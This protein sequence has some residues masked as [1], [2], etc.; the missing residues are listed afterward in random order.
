MIL[1]RGEDMSTNFGF[2]VSKESD[3]Y[4]ISY[5][6]EDSKHVGEICRLL[7]KQGLP[8]WYD[9]G[10]KH[11]KYWDAIIAERVDNCR[12]A[13]FFITEG[14]FRKAAE[15]GL[16]RTNV[17]VYYEYEMTRN[18]NKRALIVMLEEVDSRIVPYELQRWWTEIRPSSRQGVLAY[19]MSPEQVAQRILAEIK[20]TDIAEGVA[21]VAT[22]DESENGTN[23]K[24][25]RPSRVLPLAVSAL[26]I[27]IVALL[28]V[29]VP[30]LRKGGGLP[31]VSEASDAL[32]PAGLLNA[33][34]SVSGYELSRGPIYSIPYG[35][36]VEIRTGNTSEVRSV[37]YQVVGSEP[38]WQKNTDHCIVRFPEEAGRFI[39]LRVGGLTA[40]GRKTEWQEYS[41][42]LCDQKKTEDALILCAGGSILE[43]GEHKICLGGQVLCLIDNGDREITQVRYRIDNGTVT[44]VTRDFSGFLDIETQNVSRFS[45]QACGITAGGEETPWQ[46]YSFVKHDLLPFSVSNGESKL[47]IGWTYWIDIDLPV[48]LSAPDGVNVGEFYYKIGTRPME[49]VVGKGRDAIE[50]SIPKAYAGTGPFSFQV[51]YVTP[52]GRQSAW[53]KYFLVAE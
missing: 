15:Y 35:M 14:I 44:D 20:R 43:Q 1:E 49:T 50:V 9:Y 2:D 38:V 17:G 25:L 30:R 39:L 33:T 22:G 52:D 36:P 34:V 46:T 41:L 27:A 18:F 19:G 6:T 26:A 28:C 53:E 4:F 31:P 5:N 11:D 12:E 37:G 8:M 42:Y 21:A 29:F 51:C 3:Y 16:D 48:V 13:I 10:I 47:D 24:S 7:H 40:D 23:K 45:L 32:I